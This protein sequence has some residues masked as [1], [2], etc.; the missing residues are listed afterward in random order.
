M[1]KKHIRENETEALTLNCTD[2]TSPAVNAS[3]RAEYWS[4][5]TL[6]L[7]GQYRHSDRMCKRCADSLIGRIADSG[8]A[9]QIIRYSA[10]PTMH[11]VAA[12]V[13]A[14]LQ[15]DEGRK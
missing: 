7:N 15:D 5:H 1:F 10:I 6:L 12:P 9:T 11:L 13:L 14:P 4:V 8:S 3:G 2:C